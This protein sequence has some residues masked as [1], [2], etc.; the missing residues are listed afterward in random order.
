MH[1]QITGAFKVVAK[2]SCFVLLCSTTWKW[3]II[4]MYVVFNLVNLYD[5]LVI[6]LIYFVKNTLSDFYY[7][8][9]FISMKN[10]LFWHK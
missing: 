7:L 4:E 6:H 8:S 1:L 5:F 10:L 2:A 3:V 9:S